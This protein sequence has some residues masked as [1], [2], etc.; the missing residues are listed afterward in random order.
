MTDSSAT[1][2]IINELVSTERSYVKR[3]HILKHDYA[4]PLRTFS[5]SKDTAI[6]PAYEAKTLFGNVDDLLPVHEAFLADLDRMMAPDGPQAVESVGDVVLHHFKQLR[7]FERYKL[8][9][10]K[11]E[12]A[13]AIFEREM[14]KRSSNF[15]SFV[16][17]IKY[18]S[19]DTKNRIGLRELLMDPVQRI[20]RY[21]LMF[22]TMTKRMHPGDT[23]RAKLIE[24]D[25]IA[26][27]IAHAEA[28]EETKRATILNCLS[29]SIEGFPVNLISAKRRFIDFID[30]QDTLADAYSSASSSA[31]LE[32][33]HCSLV[34]FD[35]KLLII[36]RPG[37]G[38]KSGRALAGMDHLDKVTKGGFLPFGTRKSGM[39]CKG[40][41]DISEVAATDVG[42][43]DFHLYLEVPPEDQT[44]R[45]AG[46]PFRALSVVFPPAP[47]GLNPTRTETEKKR[48]LEK[49]WHA[50]AQCRTKSGNSV[51]LRAEERETKVVVHIDPLGASDPLPFGINAAPYVAIRVQPMAGYVSRYTQPKDEMDESEWD[52]TMRLEL[53][54]RNSKNQHDIPPDTPTWQEPVEETIYEVSSFS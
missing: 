49:L 14:A 50:Q 19:A 8:Y 10:S 3:L 20:P 13:Q 54:R 30:V 42:G 39:S 11:R 22:R 38:E 44:D 28:D 18:S 53:A 40:V 47:I 31:P 5:R 21:T 36:K 27:K 4:D 15:A 16:D 25:E 29:S 9:Y 51:V 41:F 35:D 46:R 24:A 33:L 6:I 12:E 48:F 17:R 37:N 1:Q 32:T 26:S 2:D 45:W 52:L 34:L 23:Q 43:S 7:G